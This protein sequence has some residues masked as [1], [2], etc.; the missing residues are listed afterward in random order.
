MNIRDWNSL[1]FYW[2]AGVFSTGPSWVTKSVLWNNDLFQC[3]DWYKMSHALILVINRLN[4]VSLRK[5]VWD[6]YFLNFLIILKNIVKFTLNFAQ[7]LWLWFRNW[8]NFFFFLAKKIVWIR[9]TFP[10]LRGT[11]ISG[12]LRFGLVPD[13]LR[14]AQ[15]PYP[16]SGV[17]F[18]K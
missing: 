15:D 13:V 18:P 9:V 6:K 4:F 1:S 2:K 12:V 3:N 11:Y 7:N 10:D 5:V 17:I 14:A 8:F 16:C